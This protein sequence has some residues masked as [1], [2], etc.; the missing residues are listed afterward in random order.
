MNDINGATFTSGTS[1]GRGTPRDSQVFIQ[2]NPC[3]IRVLGRE[4]LSKNKRQS[5][6]A[7]PSGISINVLATCLERR[8][9][10]AQSIRTRGNVAHSRVHHHQ[11]L[12][13]NWNILTLTGKELELVEEAKTYHLD[14]IKVSSTKRHN[15]GTVDLDGEWK[16]FYSGADMSAQ[17]GVGIFTTPRFS[18][19]VSHWISLGSRVS[20]VKLKVLDRSLCLLQVHA[21]NAT[22]EYQVFVDGVNAALLQVSPT[23]STVLMRDFN[24]HD[25]TD[26]DTWK[27]V[28]G[29]HGV[30]ALNENGRYLLQLCCGN[31]LR[32]MN[33][34]FQH[35]EVHK[36][37]WYR[38]SMDQKSLIDFCIVSS[39]LFSDVL[40]IRVKR[41][42]ELS[43]DHHLVVCSLQLSKPWPNRR[44][45]ISSVTYRIKWEALEDK[46]VRKQ[47]AS[48][49][50]SKFR[51]LPDVSEDIE[52]EWLLFR[53]AII[54]S[55]A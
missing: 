10:A 7:S 37:T 40:D 36:Y 44:S 48:S 52:K 9:E 1:S 41:G 13:G 55:A 4:A 26:T 53:S 27:G 6:P 15:S 19:C 30:T 46:E 38:P 50:S 39:D 34:F 23:E 28:I 18:D 24:V 17:A 3:G 2:R 49:I 21:P 14:L 35:R 11:L 29:K 5:P 51:Q 32:I 33:T 16:L 20:M 22:S 43:T 54:S 25:G 12:F 42:S 45:N 31:G 8:M 47:F